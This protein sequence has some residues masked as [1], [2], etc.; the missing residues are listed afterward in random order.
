MLQIEVRLR[1]R[2]DILLE[3]VE[4]CRQ[5]FWNKRASRA[6]G[7]KPVDLIRADKSMDHLT[8]LT[9]AELLIEN[10][11]RLEGFELELATLRMSVA[12]WD[13]LTNLEERDFA[14]VVDLDQLT[15]L[16]RIN[17]MSAS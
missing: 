8:A 9:M 10:L 2:D 15:N 7:S 13:K 12:E 11:Q 16:S 4:E 14:V 6:L 1:G 3:L 17:P 5:D